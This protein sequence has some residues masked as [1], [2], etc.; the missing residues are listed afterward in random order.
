MDGLVKGTMKEAIHIYI[1]DCFV[2]HF[3]SMYHYISPTMSPSF[4]SFMMVVYTVLDEQLII[5]FVL[6]S[7]FNEPYGNVYYPSLSDK[8]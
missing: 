7:L 6:F 3:H 5:C 8:F 4:I 1:S 2:F